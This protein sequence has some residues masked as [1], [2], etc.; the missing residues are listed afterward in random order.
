MWSKDGLAQGET[1][2]PCLGYRFITATAEPVELGP[3]LPGTLRTWLRETKYVYSKVT[4]VGNLK[5]V[6]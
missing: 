4:K 1:Q 5:N 2:E 3:F 6:M